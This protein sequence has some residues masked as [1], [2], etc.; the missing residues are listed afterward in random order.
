MPELPEVET[1]KSQLS[2][3]LP[4]EIKKISFSDKTSRLI[5]QK[6]FTPKS[7]ESI[8]EISRKGKFLIFKLDNPDHFMISHLGMSGSWRITDSRLDEIDGK[9]AHIIIETNK[10]VL[11]YIDPRRFGH[12]YF[13]NKKNFE[14]KLNSY[15]MD[16]SEPG[17]DAE[18]IYN[19]FQNNPNKVLKTFL[20]DQKN[21]SGVGNYIA[22]EI[23]A[24][25]KLLPTRIVGPLTKKD[26]KNIKAAI[27]LIIL[28]AVKT[29]GT[30]F[31]G[32]YRDAFGEKG[33]GVQHLVVFHQKIC[34]M[35]K[36]T[37]IIKITIGGR[38]TYYCP[39]CQK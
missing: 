12:L 14:T 39:H 31:G 6:D 17:F 28:G 37:P 30:T 2:N 29:Q 25:A 3:F 5:K 23:C 24:R 33:E 26:C 15:P 1:I 38:G 8:I 13:L 9:H 10:K 4:L 18:H 19:I 20:L 32:G 27:D 35:C 21:F 11:S 16:I 22:S 34:Q 36:K 7:G